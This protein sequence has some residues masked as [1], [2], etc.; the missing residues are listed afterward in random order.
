MNKQLGRNPGR[1]AIVLFTDGV[2]TTSRNARLPEQRDGRA[3][4]RRVDLSRSVRHRARHER[5]RSDFPPRQSTC[6]DR[7][8][9]ASLAAADGRRWWWQ[10]MAARVA[11]RRGD[12]EVGERYLEELANTTGG[13]EYRADTLQNMSYAFANVAE[14][15]RRQYSIGY[16]PKRPPQAGHER[17]SKCAPNNQT[18][19]C[20]RATVTSSIHRERQSVEVSANKCTGVTKTN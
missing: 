17:R 15:L 5:R 9:A 20:A 11:P 3:G 16:Y 8:S 1:K 12:Y 2:D 10:W 6:L 4:A 18:S 19:R 7:F 13:R 14:E